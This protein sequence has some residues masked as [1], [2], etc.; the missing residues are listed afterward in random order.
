M[1][2]I[3]ASLQYTVVL[4]RLAIYST[5]ILYLPIEIPVYSIIEQ[6]KIS[7]RVFLKYLK[8]TEVVY[9]IQVKLKSTGV[10]NNLIT[11]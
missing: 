5:L 9:I 3:L 1:K 8:A 10:R 2:R 6:S 11:K 7:F 4:I